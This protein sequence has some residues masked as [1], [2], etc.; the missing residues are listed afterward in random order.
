MKKSIV[1]VLLFLF[2]N[3]FIQNKCVRVRL[4]K[5]KNVLH[6]F[7]VIQVVNVV[8][9]QSE[10]Y[11]RR[12]IFE[13]SITGSSN[14]FVIVVHRSK[15]LETSQ[16]KHQHI[17][18]NENQYQI[19]FNQISLCYHVFFPNAMNKKFVRF[20][21][22]YIRNVS[23]FPAKEANNNLSLHLL[24]SIYRRFIF[25]WKG[26]LYCLQIYMYIVSLRYLIFIQA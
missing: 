9:C 22:I 13:K 19:C 12:I 24:E 10:Y 17:F 8:Q 11:W 18:F 16:S 21:T 2:Y 1:P 23:E 7:F 25:I 15:R 5:E 26:L 20:K 3:K 14:D 6:Y 4:L